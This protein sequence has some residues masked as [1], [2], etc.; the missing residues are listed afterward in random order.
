MKIRVLVLTLLA[1][2]A[3]SG[4]VPSA[5]ASNKTAAVQATQPEL[6]SGSAMVLDMQTHRV[7]YSRN[8]DEV[9]PI[10]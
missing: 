8:P 10:A 1:L 5:L 2:Q 6:A 9:V 7:I 4:L 3:G